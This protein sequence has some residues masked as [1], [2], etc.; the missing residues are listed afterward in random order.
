M[1]G[2]GPDSRTVWAYEQ[3]G[4]GPLEMQQWAVSDRRSP[5]WL[6]AVTAAVVALAVI[7]RVRSRRMV[8]PMT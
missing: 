7:D 4:P 3:D 6:W 1:L 8:T 2:F 5:A